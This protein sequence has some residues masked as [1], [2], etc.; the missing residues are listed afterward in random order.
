MCLLPLFLLI[1]PAVSVEPAAGFAEADIA[2]GWAVEFALP[3][4][5]RADYPMWVV[6]NESRL[7][8][9]VTFPGVAEYPLKGTIE[10][11]QFSIVWQNPI[12]GE[13]VDVIFTGTV[14]G[15]AI[16][17]TAKIGK[18]PE[19]DLNGRRTDR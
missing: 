17:G 14:K 16:S 12:D 3:W 11:D 1:G 5:G 4:G 10:A 7:S 6:Q 18:W 2:G 9:R 8:G 15:D 19:G 13:W